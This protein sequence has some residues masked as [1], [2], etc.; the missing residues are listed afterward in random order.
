ME[1]Q[2]DKSLSRFGILCYLKKKKKPP[3]HYNYSAEIFFHK[4]HNAGYKTDTQL[5]L[6]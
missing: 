2:T 3:K 6:K 5:A 1:N 4:I